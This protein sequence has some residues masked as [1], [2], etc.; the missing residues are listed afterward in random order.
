M[1]WIR[2]ETLR[3]KAAVKLGNNAVVAILMDNGL[4]SLQSEPHRE[5]ET[6]KLPLRVTVEHD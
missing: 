1:P 6:W 3:L 2:K 5:A 4:E